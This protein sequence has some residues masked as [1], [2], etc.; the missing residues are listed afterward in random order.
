[1]SAKGP[2]PSV[3]MSVHFSSTSLPFWHLLLPSFVLA[4]TFPGHCLPVH[5]PGCWAGRNQ[6]HP[7]CAL[8]GVPCSDSNPFLS[9][10][11]KVEEGLLED[12]GKPADFQVGELR[13]GEGTYLTQGHTAQT[14]MPPLPQVLPCAIKWI[15]SCHLTLGGIK[16]DFGDAGGRATGEQAAR[17]PQLPPC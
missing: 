13:P 10:W 4:M 1:M 14:P 11:I 15:Q 2:E 8:M 3:T 5:M 6:P 16:G 7:G 17:H 12:S 9:S